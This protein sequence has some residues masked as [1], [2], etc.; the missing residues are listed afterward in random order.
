MAMM[1]VMV[2]ELVLVLM[3]DIGYGHTRAP[4]IVANNISMQ[5]DFELSQ[6]RCCKF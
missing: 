2:M 4:T 3:C 6:G 5:K 1:M